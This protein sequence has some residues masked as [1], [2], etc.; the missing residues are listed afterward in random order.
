MWLPIKP[1]APVTRT[2]DI[3][4]SKD[5]WLETGKARER[6]G[7]QRQRVFTKAGMV[8]GE[9]GNIERW[10]PSALLL[11]P[12]SVQRQGERAQRDASKSKPAEYSSLRNDMEPVYIKNSCRTSGTPTP[13]N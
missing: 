1:A 12:N 4:F 3:R 5:P 11:Q 2:V 6:V 9:R 7:I 10:R 8:R 13:P